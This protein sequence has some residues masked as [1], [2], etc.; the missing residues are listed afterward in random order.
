MWV[1]VLLITVQIKGEIERRI[2]WVGE[3]NHS[4]PQDSPLARNIQNERI[5]SSTD[6][7]QEIISQNYIDANDDDLQQRQEP[8]F[9]K[10]TYLEFPKVQ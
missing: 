2:D 8:I 10:G 5:R 7:G 4:Q 6:A 3:P 9:G 1:I